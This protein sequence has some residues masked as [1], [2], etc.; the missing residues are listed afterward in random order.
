M[1]LGNLCVSPQ[2]GLKPKTACVSPS[3][4]SFATYIRSADK[5]NS[6]PPVKQNPFILEIT[7]FGDSSIKFITV[8][9]SLSK[10]FPTPPLEISVPFSSI[11]LKSIP[12][13]KAFPA[14]VKIITLILLLLF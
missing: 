1:Y 6:N 2:E 10:V 5:A 7:A 11:C 4:A 9:A 3:L 12:A 8:F 13:V 14:P